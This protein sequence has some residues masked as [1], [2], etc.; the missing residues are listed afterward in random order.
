[1]A[2]LLVTGGAGYIGSHALLALRAAGHTAVVVDDLRTGHAFLAG[3]TPLER[4]DVGDRGAIE[5]VLRG[6][7]PFDGVLHFAASLK[8]VFSSSG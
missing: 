3:D 2:H 1:M 5:R 4:C 7:G 8:T 6:R